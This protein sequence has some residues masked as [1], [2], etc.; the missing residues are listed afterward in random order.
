[1]RFACPSYLTLKRSVCIFQCVLSSSSP[2]NHWLF[3][4][5]TKLHTQNKEKVWDKQGLQKPN[6]KSH[7]FCRFHEYMEWPCASVEV[8]IIA[9]R[10]VSTSHNE[11]NLSTYNRP[12]PWTPT[13]LQ[14]SVALATLRHQTKGIISRKLFLQITGFQPI[15]P[16]F[17]STLISYQEEI[18]ILMH[19]K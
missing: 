6:T 19:F 12:Q 11:L 2:S 16:S 15:C 3:L 5:I 14:V 7:C 8:A 1:M 18:G 13:G 17:Q 9:Q 4:I 10:V